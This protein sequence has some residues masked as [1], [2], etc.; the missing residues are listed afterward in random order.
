MSEKILRWFGNRRNEKV[1]DM[2]HKHL[3]LTQRA[4]GRLYH[5]VKSVGIDPSEKNQFYENISQYEMEADQLRRDMVN[6]LSI[7]NV[8]P[9]ERDDLMELVR[10]VDWIADWAREA[11]RIIV[12]V[13]F[14]KLPEEFRTIIEDMCRVNYSCIKVLAKCIKELSSDP[15]AAL[16]F[17][18]QVELFEE[19]LDDLYGAARNQLVK[20]PSDTLTIGGM[21]LLNELIEAIETVSDWC[22]NTADISRAIALR[23]I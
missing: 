5:M 13:Q 4:V 19:D 8:Y 9:S 23:V 15:E 6:E 1:L 3:D 21:I 2:T 14:E 10:A 18:D 22:E 7:R 16:D 20:V 12:I 17:A 11:A